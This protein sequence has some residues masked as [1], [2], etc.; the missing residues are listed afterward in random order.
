M[1]FRLVDLKKYLSGERISMSASELMFKIQKILKAKKVNGK[2]KT[3]KG[4]EISCPSWVY[5]EDA[6]AGNFVITVVDGTTL[7]LT[8]KI[9][10]KN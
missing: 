10:E 5:P 8:D 7:K 9:N 4:D 3:K 2:A 1:H 6:G